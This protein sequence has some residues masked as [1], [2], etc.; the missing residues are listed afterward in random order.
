MFQDSGWR[1]REVSLIHQGVLVIAEIAW[2]P[3][4][5]LQATVYLVTWEVDGGGL[6]G[7]LLTDSTTVTL[8]LWPDA[9]YR[10]QVR[11]AMLTYK[12]SK[13]ESVKDSWF[14]IS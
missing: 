1:L 5:A 7:N 13:Y 9:V 14:Y 12:L 10:I 8:S 6:R 2:E 3:Q 4:T 11:H